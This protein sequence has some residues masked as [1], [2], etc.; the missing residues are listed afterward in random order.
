MNLQEQ[1]K[2]ALD[3]YLVESDPKIGTGKNPKV[4][5]ED[6]TQMKIQVILYQ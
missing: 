4:P 3:E 2:K 5:I 1:I 6:Y